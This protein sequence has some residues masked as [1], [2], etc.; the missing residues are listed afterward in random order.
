MPT[1]KIGS[2]VKVH[3][4]I[5]KSGVLT[6][7]AEAAEPLL[8]SG[9]LLPPDN[10]EPPPPPPSGNEAPGTGKENQGEPAQATSDVAQDPEPGDKAQVKATAAKSTAKPAKAKS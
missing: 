2:P 7:D 1:Y 4:R 8:E 3:G 10:P 6:L 5:M 9:A